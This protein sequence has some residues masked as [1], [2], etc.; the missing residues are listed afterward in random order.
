M[1]NG[2]EM[3]LRGGEYEN[4]NMKDMLKYTRYIILAQSLPGRDRVYGQC[5]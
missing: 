3:G 2:E 5:I 4:S 1:S